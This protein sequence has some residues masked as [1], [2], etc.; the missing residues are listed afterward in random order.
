MT[1]VSIRITTTTRK[2]LEATQRQAF[3]AGDLSLVRRVTALLG[4]ARGEPAESVA[5]GVGVS[6]SSVYAWLRAFL[7]EGAAGLRVR[8]RGGRPSKLT[9][10][11]RE[12][13]A[14]I[15]EAG[16]EAAGFP[17][18][19]WHALLIQQVIQREFGVT[20]NVHYLATLLHS[21]GFS[22]QKARFVSDHLDAVARAAWLAYTFPAWRA[23]AEAAGGLLLFGDEASFAQWGSL[24]Y[25]WA[26]V[27]RQPVVKTTGRRKAYKVFGLIEYFSGR[28]FHRGMDGRFTGD[29]YV[30]FL[31]GILAQTTEP[32]FLVQDGAPYHRAAPVKAFFAQH[33]ERLHVTQLPS[34]SPDYNPIEFLWRAT[35]RAA[36]HN[37]Y[38]PAFDD[39]IGSVEEALAFFAAHPDRVKALFG[40]YLDDLAAEP[41][42]PASVVAAA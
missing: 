31:A 34:Y 21:L 3:K 20:Y 9:K 8:W 40:R 28:L 33:R 24:G 6:P 30:A 4:I 17:T 32:L 37:R 13:L 38:F 2:Q 22:F 29:S 39:L 7:L 27:G 35:K 16:P 10:A 19:C 23:Q 26:R 14:A 11:Q 36:T 1:P 15:I 18:G 5:A 41:P 25:T 42:A 12:R